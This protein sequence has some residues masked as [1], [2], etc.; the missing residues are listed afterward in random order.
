MENVN[1][2]HLYYFHVVAESGSLGAAARKLSV[3]KPTI[4]TQVRQLESFLGKELFDR[5]GGRLRLND[6]GRIA[7]RH[8]KTMFEAGRALM[9]EFREEEGDHP[10]LLRVGVAS[11]VARNLAADFFA[12]LKE[13][14]DAFIQI[15]SGDVTELQRRL[16][17]LELDILLTDSAP[18][19]PDELGFGVEALSRVP[20][21]VVAASSKVKPSTTL[22]Q[23]AADLPLFHYLS[24]SRDRWKIDHF[25][26][27]RGIEAE[28]SGETDDVSTQVSLAMSGSYF[29]IV[30]EESA[31][32]EVES[33]ALTVIER[34][35]GVEHVLYALFLQ[36]DIPA[37]VQ[38]T[39]GLLRRLEE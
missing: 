30:P 35:E 22:K 26:R 38:N 10:Q 4:S 11:S 3:T 5:R 8:T 27:E 9:R 21:V 39:I 32:A 34:L 1:F 2:N 24:D 14:E 12:P 6:E 19:N 17:A 20:L 18:P 13:V 16:S 28:V 31:A 29:V 15:R 23:L 37:L 7:H 33:G 36:R 25:L